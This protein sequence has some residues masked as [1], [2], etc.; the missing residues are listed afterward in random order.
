ELVAR[1]GAAKYDL[2]SIC[3]NMPA[4]TGRQSRIEIG[5]LSVNG[6]QRSFEAVGKHRSARRRGVAVR[7]WRELNRLTDV[8]GENRVRGREQLAGKRVRR[9]GRAAEVCREPA[10]IFGEQNARALRADQTEQ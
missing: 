7:E 9:D 5:T 8:V 10:A 4:A 3:L 1:R 2:H 6:R